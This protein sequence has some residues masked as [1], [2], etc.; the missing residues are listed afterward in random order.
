MVCLTLTCSTFGETIFV[1]TN[2]T[3]ENDGESWEDAY[4]SLAEALEEAEDNYQ[5]WVAAG[6]YYPTSNTNRNTSFI[7]PNGV[8]ILGGFP[9]TGNPGIAN[10]NPSLNLTILSGDIDQN[11]DLANNSYTIIYT[12]DVTANT[13]LDGFIIEGGNADDIVT[14]DFPVLLKNGGAAWYN[15]A[16]N[17]KDS[18]PTIKNCTFRNNFASNRGGAMF[19]KAASGGHANYSLI[20]C[21]FQNNIANRNGGAIFNAQSG[22]SSECSPI[23]SN[24]NFLSNTAGQSGGAIF[25]EGAYFGI[26]SG[27]YTDCNFNRNEATNNEGGAIY[28]NA[29]FQGITNP[30]FTNCNFLGN[31]AA[32]GSGGAIYSIASGQGIANF[33][34]INCVFDLNTSTVYGGAICNIISNQGEIKPIYTNCLFKENNA[35]FGGA[36]YS[37]GVFGSNLDVTIANCVFF[38]NQSSV[39]GAIYQNET[40]ATSLGTTKVSNSIFEQNTA[41]FSPIFHLT[42]SSSIGTNNSI[43]DVDNCLDLVQGN[44]VSEADCNGN[45]IFNQ[46][47]LFVDA[48]NGNFSVVANS[49]AID[50]GNNADVPAF[51]TE[52]VAGNPRISGGKVDIGIYEQVNNNSDNDGDE[53][54]DANDNCPLIAN[55]GQEDV[56]GDGAGT[57]CDCDDSITTG[58]SCSTGCN[59]FYLDND[60]DGFGNLSISVSTCVAPAGYVN[61]NQDFNDN[62]PTLYPNAPELCDGKD[63]DNN[64][65]VD[66]GTDDDNDGVCNEND[67]CPGGDDMVDENE[68]GIPDDCESQISLNCPSNI[69]IGASVGKNTAVVNWDEPTASTDCNGGGSGGGSCSG[70]PI[71]GFTYKGEHNGHDYYLSNSSEI[72]TNAQI[73]ATTND[74]NL[75]IINDQSE[76]DFVKSIIGSNIV[77]IGLTD[78][79]EEGTFKWVDGENMDAYSNFEGTPESA[80]YGIMY[81]WNGKWAVGGDYTK[82]YVIE[83]ACGGGNGGGLMI[84]Q[85]DGLNNGAAFPIGTTPVTYTAID[86]CDGLKTCT[87]N[88]TV[89]ATSSTIAINCPAN[90][91]INAAPGATEAIATWNEPVTTNDCG[92]SVIATPSQASGTIFPIGTTTIIYTATDNCGSQETCQFTV[93]VNATNSDISITCP[94]DIIVTAAPG[95]TSKVVTW[96]TPATTSNCTTGNITVT[97]S[98]PNGT[99]FQ[100]GTTTPVTLTAADGCGETISCTF[101]VI[102]NEGASIVN[103]NCPADITVEAGVGET[104]KIVNYSNPTGTTTCGTSGIAL[105]LLNGLASGAAFPIGTTVVEYKGTDNCGSTT[106]CSF[107]VIVNAVDLQITCPSDIVETVS[108]PSEMVTIS[109]PN[110]TGGSNC[111]AGGYTFSQTAGPN[112]GSEFGVGNT[113]IT[114]TA[115][116]NCGSLLTCSFT[117]TVN[118][119]NSNLS[120]ICPDD[121]NL[122]TPQGMGSGIANWTLP[123]ATTN[124]IIEEGGQPTCEGA[125]IA[126]FDYKGSYNGSDYYLSQGKAPWLTAMAN[127]ITAGGTLVGIED[128]AENNFIKTIVDGEIVH[129]GRNDMTTEGTEE[130]LNGEPITYS[131]FS[132]FTPNDA[133]NDY[134]VFYPWDGSWDWINNGTWKNYLMEI[135]CGGNG[136]SVPIITQIDGPAN[137]DNFPVGTTTITYQ[138]T[139]DCG[140]ITTC[141]FNVT[142]T[143]TVVVCNPDNSGGQI[144]GNEIICDPYDPQ[145]ITSSNLPTGGTGTIEYIWLKSESGCPTNISQAIPNSNSPTYNPPFITT[146]TNY[147]RWSRR[148]NCTD[149]V[150]SNCITKTVDDCGTSTNYCDLVA[151]QPWQEWISRV[152]VADLNN[153]SGKSLGYDDYTNLVANLTAGQ[154]YTVN[155]TLTFSYNQWNETVYVWMD[156]NQ[157]N[158]FNDP[159]ELVLEQLSPSNGNGGAQPDVIVGA[160]TVPAYATPGTTRMRVAMKREFSSNPCGEFIH[161]EVEDYTLNIAA[162]AS[163]RA[164]PV[165]A[166]DAYPVTGTSILEWISNTTDLETIFEVERSPDKEQFEKIEEVEVMYE[167]NYDSYYKIID[168]EPQLGANYYRIKQIFKTGET[169]YSSTKKIVYGRKQSKLHFY[170]NPAKDV[171]YVETRN[172]QGKS[173]NIQIINMLGQVLKNINLET[174]ENAILTIPLNQLDNGMHS[175]LFKVQ[176]MPVQSK[177]FLVEKM[178]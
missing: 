84:A 126:G 83:K 174:V 86:D 130:W 67:I 19:H 82:Q 159:G 138:A 44:G 100:T 8:E 140:N 55:S 69:T 146:T 158:D 73:I 107:N 3:G 99:A 37:R 155:V 29:A 75:V 40:G 74:A 35:A 76:N 4:T 57:I 56:D 173:G 12:K 58:T 60:N 120:L 51:I 72:W 32:P 10:R 15:E 105:E 1:K 117:I 27:T 22:T 68:N 88:V 71:S 94:T 150:A 20:N 164:K 111:N 132:G 156:F 7:L 103:L 11:G 36:T 26:V 87:F 139:D 95:A 89:E 81:F 9:N 39:G 108:T 148:T 171:L 80:D 168:E 65:Q 153:I 97:A 59:T 28:N 127:S 163:S 78:Q 18:N 144:S 141:S 147:V 6:T 136:I 170:P 110:P 149:W 131:N 154:E 43:F 116:D 31:N 49:P 104:S 79:A 33:S 151:D 101:N 128:E 92:G 115:T 52:D 124:C 90:I 109:W 16:S 34:L 48:A 157:D 21:V 113:V 143:E 85:T 137:G 114:Y 5:I 142:V 24:T 13:I 98:I 176:G 77:H 54:L 17:F 23:V 135:K 70:E 133:A 118:L 41:G 172:F 119:N 121:I 93:S 102:V 169:V 46:D 161:G 178:R 53:I 14:S 63:N 62:D 166:F 64:G 160:F 167:G 112:S 165:L 122:T 152:E 30:S 42:G 50:A 96:S 61:N 66:E 125:T 145:T 38:K 177:L 2:A 47:P 134:T 175:L 129:I 25:N 123:T 162:G 106:T 91:T 45:N